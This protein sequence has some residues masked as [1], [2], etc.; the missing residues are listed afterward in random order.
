MHRY[1]VLND[2]H[3]WAKILSSLEIGPIYH[4]DFSENLAQMYKEEAQSSHFNK[5]QYSLHC[6]VKYVDGKKCLYIYH[7]SDDKKHDF[8]FTSKVASHLID[9]DFEECIVIRVKSDN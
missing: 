1:Q 2:R 3:H 5:P 6:S 9:T 4:L 7:L 8:A